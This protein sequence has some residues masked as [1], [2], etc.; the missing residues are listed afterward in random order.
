MKTF[1]QYS[2]FN[3]LL[4]ICALGAEADH[5]SEKEI[6]LSDSSARV[7]AMA[8]EMIESAIR[9]VNAEYSCNQTDKSEKVLLNE[10]AKYF[11]N[12][13]TGKLVINLLNDETF[14][15]RR[16]AIVDSVYQEWSIWNGAL[17]GMGSTKL[18][19]LALSPIIKIGDNEVGVDKFEHMFG[20]GRRYFNKFYFLKKDLK[21][22]LK[23]GIVREKLILGGNTL[24]TGVFSYADLSANFNGMRFWNHFLQKRDD[25][26]G[27]KYNMGPYV[28]CVNE[29][30]EVVENNPL[31]FRNYM[32]FSMDESINCSK[33]ASD[34]GFEKFERALKRISEKTNSVVACPMNEKLRDE[35]YEKYN[36]NMKDTRGR[37]ENT[38]I[39]DWIINLKGI[40][41]LSFFNEFSKRRRSLV[42]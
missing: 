21:S 23:G 14:D 36:V 26:L 30:W 22:V 10:L 16:T 31:D 4:C 27:K 1:I 19:E 9:S 17:L 42:K 24:E 25:V 2:I 6:I 18:S 12:H 3:F 29:K 13:R 38:V 8:N 33:L 15:L 34:T 39:G 32:D 35:I 5:F 40:G 28:K 11:S 41:E 7:N 37:F 20:M